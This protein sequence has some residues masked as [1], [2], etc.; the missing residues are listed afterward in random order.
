MRRI[1]SV[2]KALSTPAIIKSESHA[3][4]QARNVNRQ[5]FHKSR[6]QYNHQTWEDPNVLAE[7]PG[8]SAV[9]SQQL[10][11]NQIHFQVM[12]QLQPSC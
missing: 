12:A 5:S 11:T 7:T 10:N 9:L 2:G 3:S 1:G 4:T 6:R 8:V